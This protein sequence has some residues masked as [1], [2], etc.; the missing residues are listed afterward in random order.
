MNLHSILVQT[1]IYLLFIQR[2]FLEYVITMVCGAAMARYAHSLAENRRP[3]P[4]RDN[5][6]NQDNQDNQDNGDNGDDGDINESD[7]NY[8]QL[9]ANMIK[10]GY[11]FT[12]Y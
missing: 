2:Q 12:N 1:C 10:Y 11:K 4:N 9:V 8:M 5:G 7:V 6:D 3:R